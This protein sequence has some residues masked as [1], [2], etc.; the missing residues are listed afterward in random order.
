MENNNDFFYNGYDDNSQDNTKDPFSQKKTFYDPDS[1]VFI[2][3][4][5]P[6]VKV[7]TTKDGRN[8][9]ISSFLV[10]LIVLLAAG[11][12]ITIDI[13]KSVWSVSFME[14]A[15]QV[16]GVVTKV[17]HSTGRKRTKTYY[18]YYHYSASDGQEYDGCQTLTQQ[19]AFETGFSS[20]NKVGTAVTVFFD[21]SNPK[22]SI[23]M[24]HEPGWVRISGEII[25]FIVGVLLLINGIRIYR[26][27]SNGEY[28]VEELNG[29]RKI[30]PLKSRRRGGYTYDI[31]KY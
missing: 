15:S 14:H 1:G 20:R 26:A 12:M 9:Y 21:P 22:T 6:V 25:G 27:F 4:E 2:T 10:A 17:S 5:D 30:R 29:R 8:H 3:N 31:Q 24:V 19:K 11:G 13:V 18:V 16:Q 23:I 28:V 7:A